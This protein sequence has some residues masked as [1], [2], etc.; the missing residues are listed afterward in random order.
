MLEL[1]DKGIKTII[2]VA[3]IQ[4]TKQKHRSDKGL[5]QSFRE[6]KYTMSGMKTTLNRMNNRLDKTT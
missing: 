3:Y 2:S 5:N 4:K 1:A 6:K